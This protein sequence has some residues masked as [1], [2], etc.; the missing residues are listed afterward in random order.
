MKGVIQ[1][2]T[3]LLKKIIVKLHVLLKIWINCCNNPNF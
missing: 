1:K 2:Y 3:T